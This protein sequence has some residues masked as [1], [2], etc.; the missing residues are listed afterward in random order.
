MI[1][2][3]HLA[4]AFGRNVNIL[5]MQTDGLS[6]EDSF[7]QLPFRANCMNWIVGHIVTNRHTVLKL[8]GDEPLAEVERV[9]R[10]V[11]E[12]QPVTGTGEGVLL[13]SELLA[14][15]EKA[16]AALAARLAEITPA[17]L[18]RQVALFGN[19]SRSVAEWLFFLYFH[20]TYHAGQTEILR[21]AAGKDDKII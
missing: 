13:L 14:L 2:P 18:E 3:T 8:L 15:L 17:A 5:K 7:L 19:T 1:S 9:Q 10:Y 6:Q 20:D 12:S 16:Q 11:R 4:E 21:Q